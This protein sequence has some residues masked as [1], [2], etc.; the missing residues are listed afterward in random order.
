VLVDHLLAWGHPV[1]PIYPKVAAR[2]RE[3]YR[4][5]PVKSDA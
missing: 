2:A 5:G 1:Y 3:G 4:T